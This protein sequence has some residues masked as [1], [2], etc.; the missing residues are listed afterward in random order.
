MKQVLVIILVLLLG[1]LVCTREEKLIPPWDLESCHEKCFQRGQQIPWFGGP[2][3]P[4]DDP[5]NYPSSNYDVA[6]CMANC[7]LH[8]WYSGDR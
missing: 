5:A 8:T 7:D 6:G 4:W 1:L 2:K 3:G